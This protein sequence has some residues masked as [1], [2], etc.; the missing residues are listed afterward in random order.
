VTA[1]MVGYYR[2]GTLEVGAKVKKGDIIA[3]VAALGLANDIEAPADG[4]I[5]EVFVEPNQPVEYGQVLAR[6]KP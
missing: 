2:A 6:I 5:D 1:P 3:A 4:E